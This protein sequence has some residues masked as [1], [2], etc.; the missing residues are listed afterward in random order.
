MSSAA[1]KKLAKRSPF[2]LNVLKLYAQFVRLSKDRPGLLDKVRDEFRAAS[3]LSPK[4]DS[5][6]IDF[7]LRRAK[8]QLEMLKLNVKAVKVL[9]IDHRDSSSTQN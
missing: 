9:R 1:V 2:Q 5:L 3:H 6:L 8:N 4:Q 7:K